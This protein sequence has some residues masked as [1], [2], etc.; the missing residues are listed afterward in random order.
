MN[1]SAA[2]NFLES[3]ALRKHRTVFLPALPS[4][5]DPGGYPL[6]SRGDSCAC[7]ESFGWS[8]SDTRVND[9]TKCN[10]GAIDHNIK[11]REA[12]AILTNET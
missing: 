2:L 10:C 5:G 11:V 4:H 8:P 9:E 1:K 6:F 12:V 3:S 7:V